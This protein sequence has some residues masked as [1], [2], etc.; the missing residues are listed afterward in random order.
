MRR[1]AL[2][3]LA[4]GIAHAEPELGRSTRGRAPW[5]EPWLTVTPILA[6]SRHG[7]T[8]EYD[9]QA[10]SDGVA[11]DHDRFYELVGR[12]DLSRRVEMRR[13]L[14]I[15]AIVGG[16]ALTVFGG[17]ELVKKGQ[18]LGLLPYFGG[19]GGGLVGAYFMLSPDPTSS[20]QARALVGVS[21]KF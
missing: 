16:A 19:F 12:S 3:L 13:A 11:I 18:P 2:V 15:A 1:F 20:D 7:G 8:F 9:W 5:D 21:G 4:A 10:F 6:S 14:G 17:Y